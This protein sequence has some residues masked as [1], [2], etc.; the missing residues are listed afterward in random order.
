MPRSR[1]QKQVARRINI[2]Y[3]RSDSQVRKTRRVLITLCALAAVA[4]IGISAIRSSPGRKSW[5]DPVTLTTIHNP[6]DLARAHTLFEKR[7]ET[8]HAG[9]KDGAFTRTVTDQACL[10]CHDGAIH[11][12]NQKKA[13]DQSGVTMASFTLA[14]KDDMHPGGARSAGCV[15]CHT[16]HRGETALLGREDRN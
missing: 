9:E 2:F 15:H 16:E 4:W 3:F 14:A 6:G 8:C 11:R 12:D 5:L 1:T 13:A 10:H 7:C